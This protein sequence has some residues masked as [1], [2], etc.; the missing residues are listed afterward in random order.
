MRQGFIDSGESVVL[1]LLLGIFMHKMNIQS[2]WT[3]ERETGKEGLKYQCDFVCGGT[4]GAA[5]V[6]GSDVSFDVGDSGQ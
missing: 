5:N 6:D 1:F 4:F 3:D 2:G